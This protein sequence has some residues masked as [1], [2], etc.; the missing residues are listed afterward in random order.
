M[1]SAFSLLRCKVI[2]FLLVCLLF[3]IPSFAQSSSPAVGSWDFTYTV[4]ELEMELEGTLTIVEKN[5]NFTGIVRFDDIDNASPIFKMNELEAS[6]NTLGFLITEGAFAPMKA[7][8]KLK[9]GKWEGRMTM[10]IPWYDNYKGSGAFVA[11]PQSAGTV[12]DHAQVIK[13]LDNNTLQL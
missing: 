9:A 1:N 2:V 3:P 10:E 11:T 13:N 4:E 7:D 6:N 12:I 8:L 5:G